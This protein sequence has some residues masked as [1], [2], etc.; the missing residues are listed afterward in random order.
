GWPEHISMPNGQC[1]QLRKSN[2]GFFP[3]G[4]VRTQDELEVPSGPTIR[5]FIEIVR[6]IAGLKSF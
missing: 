4:S 6:S 1:D 5:V 2:G 3:K